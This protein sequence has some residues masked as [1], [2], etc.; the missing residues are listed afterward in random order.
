MTILCLW[1]VVA[2]TKWLAA[3]SNSYK[4]TSQSS[5]NMIFIISFYS[6]QLWLVNIILYFFYWHC[7][8][9]IN[10]KQALL[11]FWFTVSKNQIRNSI[12]CSSVNIILYY[13]KDAYITMSKV[14]N[15]FK[16]F[17]LMAQWIN[18]LKVLF[19]FMETSLC[20]KDNWWN[21]FI[22]NGKEWC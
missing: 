1:F 4:N 22:H 20:Q 21:K 14:F 5:Y 18:I 13:F 11:L 12:L 9:L 10:T 2:N 16:L 7:F 6:I 8:F 17:L 19:I 15:I 3:N